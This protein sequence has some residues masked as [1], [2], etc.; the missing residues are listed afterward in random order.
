VSRRQKNGRLDDRGVRR[1][2]E[3]GRFASGG[4]PSQGGVRGTGRQAQGIR[5]TGNVLVPCDTRRNQ[6]SLRR[7]KS[8]LADPR[9]TVPQRGNSDRIAKMN[10][11]SIKRLR[12]KVWP[13]GQRPVRAHMLRTEE[14]RLTRSVPYTT[15]ISPGPYSASQQHGTIDERPK[16]TLPNEISGTGCSQKRISIRKNC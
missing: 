2:E 4:K 14:N 15:E 9:H 12:E 5:G 11:T 10:H 6:W 16:G 7:R 3:R 8:G 13:E 1:W